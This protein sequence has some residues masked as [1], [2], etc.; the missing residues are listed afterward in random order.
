MQEVPDE[1]VERELEPNPRA[2]YAIATKDLRRRGRE[3]AA[4]RAA[5][6]RFHDGP[7]R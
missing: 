4:L 7:Y 5:R 6:E 1:A 2:F 3:V